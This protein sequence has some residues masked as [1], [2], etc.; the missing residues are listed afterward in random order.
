MGMIESTISL[1]DQMSSVFD[2]IIERMNGV[3]TTAGSVESSMS[4]MF[5]PPNVTTLKEEVKETAVA[6]AEVK[7][8]MEAVGK[9][10]MVDAVVKTKEEVQK[11]EENT[12]EAKNRQEEYNEKV[13]E[14][15]VQ[16]GN[17]ARTIKNAVAAYVSMRTIKAFVGLSDEMTNIKTRLNA[18]NDGHQTTLE[19]QE[20]IFASSQRARGDYKMTMDVVSK[21]GAQAKDAFSNNQETIAFAENLNKMF[22]ISGT[23]AQGVESVMYNLTQAMG[24]GVLRGQDLNAVMSNTPQLMQIVAEYM[25]ITVGEIRKM[26][27]EGELSA[28]VIKNALLG[29]TAEIN[30]EFENMP[31]TFADIAIGIKNNFIR[32]LQPALDKLNEFANSEAFTKFSNIAVEGLGRVANMALAAT[33]A[34]VG[35]GNFIADH[36][37]TIEPI[38]W[39]VVGALTAWTIATNI[40]KIAQM[41]LNLAMLANPL[42]IIPAIIGIVIAAYMDW[43]QSV[44]GVAIANK[45][46]MDAILT[47]YENIKYSTISTVNNMLNSFDRFVLGMY[48]VGVGVGN[49]LTDMKVAGLRIIEG[50]VNGA[51][52]LIK[53]LIGFVN[54]IPGVSIEL[55]EKVSFASD[56][57]IN[58]EKIKQQRQ[59]SLQKIEDNISQNEF[60]RDRALNQLAKDNFSAQTART[61]EILNMQAKKNSAINPLENT[62]INPDDLNILSY[63]ELPAI[64][65]DAKGT[66]KNTD[67]LK[68]G[69]KV[70]NEDIRH[71]KELAERRAI[72]NFTFDKLEVI[73]N[74]SFG[75]IHETA[76]LDGWMD[77]LTDSLRS[78]VDST[79][80]GVPNYEW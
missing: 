15:N 78:A 12:K 65:K 24:S 46:A 35:M 2:T 11:V 71:L 70:E 1:K 26:A 33:E 59:A 56:A 37:S 62:K 10:S 60:N 8:E 51:I 45:I 28:Q 23:S 50:F 22:K 31:K 74:N 63:D 61:Q 13:K 36:W 66:K 3:I 80:G 14:G 77:N 42:F 29:A 48:K 4:G 40:Q 47:A 19:L 7:K 53:K 64:A 38:L 79:M 9:T 18:I 25:G 21:L 17:L 16:A 20:M 44:G 43:A 6:V 5:N 75:D 39:G 76:D 67:K 41:E 54:N 27:E 58:A 52:D 69:I 34:V 57:A 73:A 55:I 49:A 68:D 32:N 72:Q 30:V